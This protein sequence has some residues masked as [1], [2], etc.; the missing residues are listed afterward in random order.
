MVEPQSR[1]EAL[2]LGAIAL[3]AI[4]YFAAAVVYGAV[5]PTREEIRAIALE[6]TCRT[7]VEANLLSRCGLK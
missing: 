4:G 2:V 7:L 1:T 3:L 5:R 6:E